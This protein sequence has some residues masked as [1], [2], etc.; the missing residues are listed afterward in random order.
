MASR[1]RPRGRLPRRVYWVRRGLVLLVALALVLG[2]A[3]LIG[4]TGSDG[5]A[6]TASASNAAATTQRGSG[7]VL[8]P[9]PASGNVVR[10]HAKV[11]LLPPTGSCSPEEISVLPM[12]PIASAGG[13][14]VIRLRL[15]GTQP[16]CSFAVSSDSVVVKVTRGSDRFWSSQD[17]RA[18]IPS[19][20]VVVRSAV[21]TYVPVTWSGRRS[22]EDCSTAT[23]WALPGFYDVYAAAYGSTPAGVRF[24]VTLPNRRVITR[25]AK[26]TP[27]ATPSPTRGS[28]ATA[29]PRR[30]ASASPSASPSTSPSG[31]RGGGS[32]CGGDNAAA[33]C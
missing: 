29:T 17:C 25:T 15:D 8:G 28:S 30:T 12:V 22:D 5:P 27:S 4:G 19:Q 21:P 16:S 31:K 23:G 20:T 32:V 10:R 1:R 14:I 11:P 18:S 13:P 26:P 7:P 2:V 3:R 6:R 33:S 24:E 9:F